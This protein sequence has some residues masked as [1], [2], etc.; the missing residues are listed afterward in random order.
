MTTSR[1]EVVVNASALPAAIRTSIARHLGLTV[2]DVDA[3]FTDW[4]R[5]P[6]VLATII[7]RF[8]LCVDD[9]VDEPPG[10]QL[11]VAGWL[12]EI[13]AKWLD[14]VIDGEEHE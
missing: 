2:A 1:T 13:E 9:E 12:P 14:G 3:L 7:E 10:L 6:G 8:D 4:E 11:F 5:A